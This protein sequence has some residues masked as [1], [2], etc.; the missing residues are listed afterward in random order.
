[1]KWI[2]AYNLPT[3]SWSSGGTV[4]E[5]ERPHWDLYE[6]DAGTRDSAEAKAKL[7]RR[8]QRAMTPAQAC[9]LAS[10][11]QEHFAAPEEDRVQT[12]W[13]NIDTHELR[14]AQGLRD[15]GL[16]VISN[17]GREVKLT[18]SAFNKFDAVEHL[19]ASGKVA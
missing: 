2:A 12:P 17:S 19:R 13:V 16:V 7:L 6:V 18:V 4:S 5:Y 14:A 10:L 9:L 8:R 1:M 3:A 15:K 11:L